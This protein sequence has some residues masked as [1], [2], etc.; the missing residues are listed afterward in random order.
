MNE[1]WFIKNTQLLDESSR[2]DDLL[3]FSIEIERFF[4]KLDGIDA[5]S[6]IWFIGKFWSGKSNFLNQ[7]QKNT[8]QE[9]IKWFQFDAWKYPERAHL[10][11]S[12]TLEIARQLDKDKFDQTLKIIDWKQHDDK[13]TL[14]NVLYELPGDFAKIIPGIKAVKEW[15]QYFL[16]VSPAK[17]TFEIQNILQWIFSWI[18]ENNIYIVVEDIDRS[19]D[20]GVYFLETLSYFIKNI[21]TKKRIIVIVPIGTENYWDQTQKISYSKCLDY[22]HNFSL[23]EVKLVKFVEDIFDEEI[24]QNIY[25]KWKIVSFLEWIFR[26][27]WDQIT[28]RLFKSILR[29]ANISYISLF[30]KHWKIID[31]RLSIIFEFLKHIKVNQKYKLVNTWIETSTSEFNGD[32]LFSL[33]M[34]L[35]ISD[36]WDSYVQSKTCQS[37]Y[38]NDGNRLNLSDFHFRLFPLKFSNSPSVKYFTQWLDDEEKYISIP[39]DYLR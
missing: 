23:Q 11:E 19:G 37:L 35:T 16:N 20:N 10:W 17:R 21:D 7:A 36:V 4:W 12:F 5:S 13:K 26:E 14:L 18:R 31:F 8:S 15:I 2:N 32:D 24:I 34:W 3:D 22:Y 38:K 39:Y 28:M 9:D 25:L 29:N 1:K 27:Y 33:F 30:K 6:V